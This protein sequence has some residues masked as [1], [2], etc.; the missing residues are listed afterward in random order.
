MNV[1]IDFFLLRLMLFLYS[2]GS[3]GGKKKKI[4]KKKVKDEIANEKAG[5]ETGVKEPEMNQD[6]AEPI[7][8]SHI[9]KV[10]QSVE[11]AVND[12]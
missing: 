4:R 2:D 11:E 5:E 3:S 8:G 9:A 7:L 6:A 1:P 12:E 10:E